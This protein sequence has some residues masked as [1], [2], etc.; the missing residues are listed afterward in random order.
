MLIRAVVVLLVCLAL[1]SA[2]LAQAQQQV[3][4][5]K[6]GVLGPGTTSVLA[7]S[8]AV[9]PKALRELGYIE[10]KNIAIEYRYAANKIDRLPA[11]ADELVRLKVDVIMRTQQ[12]L[13]SPPRM[14][15]KLS[16]SFF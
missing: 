8:R 5:S 9:F 14:L 15:P 16:P 4:V 12:A 3:K 10:G 1:T 7:S 2:S 13:Q 11:L 6:I